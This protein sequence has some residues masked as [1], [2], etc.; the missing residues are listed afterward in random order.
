MA[1]KDS[2]KSGGGKAPNTG[3]NTAAQRDNKATADGK[4]VNPN[5]P[6]VDK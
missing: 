1:G 4:P 6:H 2:P 5:R 3:A